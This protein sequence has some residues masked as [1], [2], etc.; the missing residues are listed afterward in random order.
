MLIVIACCILSGI[1]L[2]FRFADIMA[3]MPDFELEVLNPRG[4]IEPPKA[5]GISP[6]ISNLT[7]KTIGLYDIGK[8]GFENFLDV[9]E[10]LLK[11]KIPTAT[12]KRYNGAFDLGEQLAFKISKE[13]DT[14]IYGV[15]D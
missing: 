11:E 3:S 1:L 7:G 10:K 6:R 15:G 13:V 14:L 8:D 9:T 12:I 4:E 5:V 2:I